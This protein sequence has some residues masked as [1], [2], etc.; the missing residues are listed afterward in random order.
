M[1]G[2]AIDSHVL[3]PL[4]SIRAHP[5]PARDLLVESPLTIR[6]GAPRPH[7][8]YRVT[9][10]IASSEI[11]AQQGIRTATPFAAGCGLA[12]HQKAC[13]TAAPIIGRWQQ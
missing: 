9:R 2:R 8:D 6:K 11:A 7:Q 10:A 5:E 4:A 12:A 1:R 3:T 13:Q